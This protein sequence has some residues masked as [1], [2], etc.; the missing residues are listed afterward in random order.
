MN[1]HGASSLASKVQ[2]IVD[3]PQPTIIKGVQEFVGVVNF[4]NRFLPK[5]AQI[6]LPLYQTIGKKTKCI[7]TLVWTLPMTKAFQAAKQA[8]TQVAMLS[9]PYMEAPTSLAVDTLDLAVGGVL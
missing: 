9:L 6:M 4:Y 1:V 3:L 8:L 2:A 5:A 7:K